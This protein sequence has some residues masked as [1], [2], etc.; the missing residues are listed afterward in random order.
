[1]NLASIL[2]YLQ[3][4]A[5][6]AHNSLGGETFFSDHAFLAD[7]YSGYEEDY[8]SV[9]ERMIGLEEECDLLKIHK[10]ASED[11]D[12]PKSFKEC[13]QNILVCEEDLCRAIDRLVEDSSEGTK[14]LIGNIADKS[15]MRQ[16]KLKQRLK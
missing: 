1:M 13:F 7:L 6:L 12:I 3:F 14:Q 4:Y 10:D 8:D 16:F 2:R 15:E 9:V 5:H 11:L